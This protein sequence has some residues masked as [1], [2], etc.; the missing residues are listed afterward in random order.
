MPLLADS[1]AHDPDCQD[2][3]DSEDDDSWHA[4]VDSRNWRSAEAQLGLKP[5]A[6][7][8]PQPA[9][10][11]C[12]I[13]IAPGTHSFMVGSFRGAAEGYIFATRNGATGYYLDQRPQPSTKTL[14]HLCSLL[15]PPLPAAQEF[16]SKQ[17]ARHQRLP[18]GRW[19]RRGGRA[20]RATLAP[21]QLPAIVTGMTELGDTQ[22][23]QAG[24]WALDSSNANSWASPER[25]VLP[26][27]Q[28]DFLTVHET[29]RVGP[30]GA[31]GVVSSARAAG[32]N[33]SASAALR[34]ETD[35][36]FGGCAVAARRGHRHPRA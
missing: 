22:W 14:L 2:S 15:P 29:K 26:K 27:S 5:P 18:D 30:A 17:P 16:I 32:W 25:C 21:E 4:F 12:S 11:S 35:L 33:C 10:P 36:G 19:V 6:G 1:D 23:R 20:G 9:P 7:R 24:L 13:A 8:Q 34:G 3:E 31:A 28:A